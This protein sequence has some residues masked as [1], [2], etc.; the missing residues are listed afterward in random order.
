VLQTKEYDGKRVRRLLEGLAPTLGRHFETEPPSM[1]KLK[2]IDS[3]GLWAVFDRAEKM[4]LDANEP[5]R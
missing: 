1:Y 2:H 3:G 4:A 5:R